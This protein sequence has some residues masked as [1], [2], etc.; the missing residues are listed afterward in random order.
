MIKNI[1][2]LIFIFLATGVFSAEKVA[3]DSILN[4][5]TDEE[6]KQAVI[7]VLQKG[8]VSNRA[9]FIKELEIVRLGDAEEEEKLYGLANINKKNANGMD[10]WEVAISGIIVVFMAIVGLVGVRYIRK[11]KSIQV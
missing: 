2:I 8:N 1:Y 3:K 4:S 11:P 9:L 5:Y 10:G 6:F 7:Q